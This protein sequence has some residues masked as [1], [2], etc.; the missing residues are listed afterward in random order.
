MPVVKLVVAPVNSASTAT[1][2]PPPNC[3]IELCP[4]PNGHI[5]AVGIDAAGRPA[6][7]LPRRLAPAA[8]RGDDRPGGEGR[9][10]AAE[11]ARTHREGPRAPTPSRERVLAAAARLLDVGFYR[12]G[13]EESAA[14]RLLRRAVTGRTAPGPVG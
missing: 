1:P 12:I 7:P 10:P 14:Q 8:R 6:V 5:Q 11:A 2:S 13:G 4:W 3:R 9:R